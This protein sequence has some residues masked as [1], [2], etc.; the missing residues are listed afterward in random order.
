MKKTIRIKSLLGICLVLGAANY[1]FSEDAEVKLDSNNG[2]TK[3][4][5][6]D[7]DAVTVFSAD[8]DGNTVING[9]AAVAGS[10]FS[11]GVS[12]FVVKNGNVGI[13]TTS[14]ATRLEVNGAAQFGSGATR[15]TFTAAGALTLSGALT[16]TSDP[17]AAL[18]AATRQYVD[19]AA[20]GEATTCPADMAYI[21]GPYPYCVDKYE[22]YLVSGAVSNDTCTNGSQAEVDANATTAIAGSASGQT[23]LVNINWCA[24][25]KACQNA[26]KH[27]LTNMEWS[28]AANYKGSK[29]NIT[30]EQSGEGLMVCNTNTGGALTTGASLTCVT[31]Q[32]VYDMIGNVWEWVDFVMT[33]DPT[34][35]LAN[36]Y[37]TGYDFATGLPTSVGATSPAFGDDYYGA[38]NGAGAARAVLRGGG[39]GS[40]ANAGV[41]AFDA[42]GA[43]SYSATAFGFRCGRRK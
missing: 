37:V 8:S 15:S 41:F 9:T 27:L 23:P 5:I 13:G 34:N 3:F 30:A 11:V 6:Q 29:W 12:T 18:H 22:A 26:G 43:P 10:G 19:A 35:G 16:L 24:A 28:N 7:K 2:S 21:P 25:K 36:N 14:P 20:V 32:G 31:Q 1:A 4:Y 33:A 17:T 39:W 40:A 38:Y 42:T